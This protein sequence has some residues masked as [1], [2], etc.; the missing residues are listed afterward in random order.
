M[1][2]SPPGMI[3]PGKSR[4][5]ARRGLPMILGDRQA[6]AAAA[7]C[8]R[9]ARVWI[10]ADGAAAARAAGRRKIAAAGGRRAWN[11]RH[12]RQDPSHWHLRQEP[13]FR[14]RP[15]SSHW[16]RGWCRRC[17]GR[18]T[19]AKHGIV[20]TGA[21]SATGEGV[22]RLKE[23]SSF[24]R[25]PCSD[26]SRFATRRESCRCGTIRLLAISGA[27]PYVSRADGCESGFAAFG[28]PAA[29]Q[30]PVPR[31]NRPAARPAIS[32]DA[33]ASQADRPRPLRN[34]RMT[35]GAPLVAF[36]RQSTKPRPSWSCHCGR[37]SS[38]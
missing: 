7:A 30:T 11:R 29:A 23:R 19:G 37:Q 13:A 24:L 33:T 6:F 20:R 10:D 38:G 32:F 18:G 25:L 15:I 36:G 27:S 2:M 4:A 35:C 3:P 14:A 8:T 21:G 1:V 16:S 34:I 17:S 5:V 31:A 22:P 26:C 12:D 28:H 9:C